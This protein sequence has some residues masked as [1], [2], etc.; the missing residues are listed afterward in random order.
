MDISCSALATL[1]VVSAAFDSTLSLSDYIVA[2]LEHPSL[3]RHRCTLNL[4]NETDRILEAFSHHANSKDHTFEWASTT[5]KKKYSESIKLLASREEWQ[6][7]AGNASAKEL[8]SFRIEDMAT[9]MKNLAPDLWV[10]LDLLLL[11]EW[12]RLRGREAD[13]DVVMEDIDGTD[14][15]DAEIEDVDELPLRSERKKEARREA[16]STVV[17]CEDD[18][19]YTTTNIKEVC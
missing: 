2:L 17:S 12:Q 1:E 6:F 13:T 7:N 8:E 3:N 19:K 4:I 18:Y 11:G 5:M 16:L 15:L 14:P 9:D 10:L